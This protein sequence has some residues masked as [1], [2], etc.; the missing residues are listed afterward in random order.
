MGSWIRWMRRRLE[1]ADLRGGWAREA[2]ECLGERLD[3]YCG[4][5]CVNWEKA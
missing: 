3:V 1:W 5:V 4:G 2:L